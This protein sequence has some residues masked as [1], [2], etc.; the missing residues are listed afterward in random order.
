MSALP[1][2]DRLPLPPAPERAVTLAIVKRDP[3]IVGFVEQAN[4]TMALMGY[5][6]HGRRHAGVSGRRARELLAALGYGE[7]IVELAGIAAYLHDIGNTINRHSHPTAGA[8]LAYPALRRLGM[9]QEEALEVCGAI[10]THEDDVT[11]PVSPVAAAVMI[12]D[13]S[14]VHRSRVHNPNRDTF[15]IHDRVNYSTT[16]SALHTEP[17]SR[18]ITLQL[19][20]DTGYA[21][22]V[23]YFEIFLGRMVM[24]RRAAELL[25]ATFSLTINGQRLL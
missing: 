13:K 17:L 12:A 20:I 19:G 22:V 4:R 5:T 9:P 3:E 25:D 15:D 18:L 21:S 16:A 23:E 24:C 10:G 6:E 8:A 14:D 11:D 1:E 2:P 7:R